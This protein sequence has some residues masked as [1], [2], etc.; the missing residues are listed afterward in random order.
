MAWK[1]KGKF[2]EID[3][4]EDLRLIFKNDKWSQFRAQWN[5]M[6]FSTCK[7]LNLVT[8]NTNLSSEL[9]NV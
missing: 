9:F 4:K 2:V 6:Y 8:G 5:S 7:T 3:F 1:D